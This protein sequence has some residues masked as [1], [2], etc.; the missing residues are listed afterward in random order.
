MFKSNYTNDAKAQRK[1]RIAIMYPVWLFKILTGIYIFLLLHM[2]TCVDR[3]DQICHGSTF[4]FNYICVFYMICAYFKLV[5]AFKQF[6]PPI[7]P[8]F[9]V[10]FVQIVMYMTVF[11]VKKIFYT[12]LIILLLIEI[13]MSLYVIYDGNNIKYTREKDVT[14]LDEKHRE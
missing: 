1:I 14:I 8:G 13:L 2:K 7:M 5:D 9:A 4:L 12:N 11:R 10:K 6:I 3:H